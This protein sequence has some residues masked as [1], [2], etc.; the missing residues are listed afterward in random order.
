MPLENAGPSG[1]VRAVQKDEDYLSYVNESVNFLVQMLAGPQSWLRWRKE[2]EV[3][4]GAGYFICTTIS[5]YQTLGEE[6]VNIL[7][8]DPSRIAVPSLTRR[9]IMVFL[10]VA[11]PYIIHKLLLRLQ[12]ILKQP[13]NTLGIP[14][15]TRRLLLGYI[16]IIRRAVEL[17]QR[18]HLAW[19]YVRGM[20]YQLAKRFTG[21]TYLSVR[22]E[23]WRDSARH[24]YRM[25]G[26]LSL[27]QLLSTLAYSAY[28]NRNNVTEFFAGDLQENTT[29]AK[30]SAASLEPRSKCSLCLDVR[31][32][33]TATSCGHLFCWRCIFEW[34]ANK[35]ECPLCR[36]KFHQSRLLYLQNYG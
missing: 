6:Y 23:L 16:P 13:T 10:H 22:S 35:A 24:S 33:T 36:E 19:F 25:L 1:I 12:N 9:V 17:L 11:T 34:A 28:S 7:Q 20:Y 30:S 32:D 26:M 27:T 3:L 14:A 29:P 2:I 21:V 15:E 31:R 4:A 8:V 18:W 5:G